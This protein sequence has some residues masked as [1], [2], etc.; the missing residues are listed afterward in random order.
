MHLLMIPNNIIDKIYLTSAFKE[1]IIVQ[2]FRFIPIIIWKRNSVCYGG[3]EKK[4]IKKTKYWKAL[5]H[6]WN[7]YSIS[8]FLNANKNC[9]RNKVIYLIS[10]QITWKKKKPNAWFDFHVPTKAPPLTT[11]ER[12]R[13]EKKYAY[14]RLLC[15]QHFLCFCWAHVPLKK[16]R[17]ETVI[18]CSE[19]KDMLKGKIRIKIRKIGTHTSIF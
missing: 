18:A 13:K 4:R 14:H 7:D 15:H 17:K 12:K 19:S 1:Q 6:T 5:T 9:I 8:K 2:S 16:Y 11:K 3:E 10:F